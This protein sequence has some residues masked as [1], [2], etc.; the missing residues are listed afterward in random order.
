MTSAETPK[1]LDRARE[2]A[3]PR[4]A[5]A[6]RSLSP[7]LRRIAH[8]HWGWCDETG[9]KARARSGKAL[10]PALA[11][12]SA[13]AVGGDPEHAIAGAAAVEI[14]HDYT[15]LHDDVMDRDQERR[16]RPTAWT[17]YGTGGAICA[18][19]ALASLA[20]Q[21]L[22]EEETPAAMRA[23]RS[24]TEANRVVIA[25]QMLDAALEGRTDVTVPS[26]LNMTRQKTGALLGCAA[27]IG[28][29]LC[30]GPGATVEA[31]R[32]FGVRLG[33]A[34]QAVDDWLGIWGEESRVGKP[35]G[36]DLRQRKASLPILHAAA[37]GN[38]AGAMVRDLLRGEEDL[39][40]LDV[41][42]AIAW[43]EET[44]AEQATLSVARRHLT[45][46]I[47]A[48]DEAWMVAWARDQLAELARYCVER[49]L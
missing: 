34:F 15:L 42:R 40:E 9:A 18:G 45:L 10:R 2:L 35:V 29:E 3:T 7:E 13:E 21:V 46:A 49:A 41:Q 44:G 26:Y 6:S 22:L 36:S 24:L 4:M 47:E 48:L 38:T 14:L 39:K 25:G 37:S 28:A 1:I 32:K 17:V 12:L 43:L 20:Q 16:G 27:A 30:D 8:Y 19:D 33:V 23:L 31:L 11:I 5:L